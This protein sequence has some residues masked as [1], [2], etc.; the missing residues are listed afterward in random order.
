MTTVASDGRFGQS[1]RARGSAVARLRIR[2]PDRQ[3]APR[4]ER[5]EVGR[6][7]GDRRLPDPGRTCRRP[8]RRR[9]GGALRRR[10][11]QGRSRDHCGSAVVGEAGRACPSGLHLDCRRR[12][13][14]DGLLPGQARSGTGAD[15]VRDSLDHPARDT[16]PR[17]GVHHRLRQ[18]ADRRSAS[19]RKGS[20]VSR[21][22]CRRWPAGWP[23]W[24]PA[25]RP[26]GCPSSVARPSVRSPSWPGC[27]SVRQ[28]GSDGVVAVPMPGRLIRGLRAGYGLT[29]DHGD[30][31]E[32][33]AD[34]LRARS[35]SA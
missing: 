11:G 23:N 31:I 9:C 1:G 21:S 25:H 20:V 24:R 33:F 34:Y 10:V 5:P 3:S 7:L 6:R 28:T 32:T 22:R 15:R 27:T 8:G 13:A 14:P 19:P 29:P 30:G 12:Q 18:S 16:V 2:R 35:Q 26:A 17:S 4:A